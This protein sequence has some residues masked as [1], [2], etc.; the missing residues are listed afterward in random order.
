[1]LNIIVIGM[2]SKSYKQ[3]LQLDSKAVIREYMTELQ[4]EALDYLEVRNAGY[5]DDGVEYIERAIKLKGLF[6]KRFKQRLLEDCD[7]LAIA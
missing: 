4:L 7:N 2:K 5:L 1:M 6:D 3:M